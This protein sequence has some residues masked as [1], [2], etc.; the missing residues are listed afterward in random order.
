MLYGI[1]QHIFKDEA[2]YEDARQDP[3]NNICSKATTQLNR[4]MSVLAEDVPDS[5]CQKRTM[6]CHN[7]GLELIEN[8]L[9]KYRLLASSASTPATE[10][11]ATKGRLE[12]PLP[13][14]HNNWEFVDNYKKV[15]GKLKWVDCYEAGKYA[16][17][18]TKY[19]TVKSLQAAYYRA[20]K[21]QK[22]QE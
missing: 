15:N 18:F 14:K 2:A 5:Q 10:T 19:T 4:I 8:L 12:Q 6:Y 1:A 9:T 7:D 22:K 13:Y 21:K 20:N 3:F 17:L 16:G 11:P